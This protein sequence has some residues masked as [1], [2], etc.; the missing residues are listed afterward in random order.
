MSTML[1][2]A[3]AS[4]CSRTASRALSTPATTSSDPKFDK[5]PAPTS[6]TKSELKFDGVTH[7]GQVPYFLKTL[8][9]D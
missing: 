5:Q 6:L 7:T 2:R 9:T 1:T 8:I 3:I 4:T